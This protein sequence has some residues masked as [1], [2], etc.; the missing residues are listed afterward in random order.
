MVK[1]Y[2][3]QK[4]YDELVKELEE[5][6]IEGR[7][8][9]AECLSQA[10][11][12]GDLSENFDYQ[13]AKEGQLRLE[14]KIAELEEI[15]RNAEIIERPLT[16]EIV[17]VGSE[18]KVKKEKEILHFTIVGSNETDPARGFISNESPLGRALLGKKINDEVTIETSKG[19]I[20]YRILSIS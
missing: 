9:V 13:E 8:K 19:P 2:L 10:K 20:R 3:T 18:V 17:K 11:N 12:L 4:R 16:S 6:K 7:Q 14:Q 5:L 1:E 15:L